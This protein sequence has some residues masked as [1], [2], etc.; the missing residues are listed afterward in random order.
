MAN[1]KN[2]YPG[3]INDS[4]KKT[5]QGAGVDVS[6]TPIKSEEEENTGVVPDKIIDM[7]SSSTSSLDEDVQKTGIQFVQN[8]PMTNKHDLSALAEE[9]TKSTA[10][11]LEEEFHSE[12]REEK[13]SKPTDERAV[14]NK[15]ETLSELLSRID[16]KLR[17]KKETVQ[18]ELGNLKKMKDTISHDIEEIKDLEASESK[19]RS[20]IEKIDSIREEVET[21]EKELNEKV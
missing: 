1:T 3:P 8:K 4:D 16:A 19:I 15:N 21:I 13:P 5:L 18:S 2:N 20:E 17:S 14:L 6:D 12:L 10:K 9:K 7:D 11:E